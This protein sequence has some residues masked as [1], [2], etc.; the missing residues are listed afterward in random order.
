[1]AQLK[2]DT[3]SE[4]GYLAMISSQDP[5]DIVKRPTASLYTCSTASH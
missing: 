3:T 5:R 1:M 2:R 4:E